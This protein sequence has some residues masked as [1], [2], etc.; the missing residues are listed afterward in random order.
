MENYIVNES[1]KELREKGRNILQGKWWQ[2]I[3]TFIIVM[4]CMSLVPELITVIFGTDMVF[5]IIS[6]LYMLLII[7]P[8]AMGMTKYMLDM[9]RGNE[10]SS[11]TAFSGFERF[12]KTVGLALYMSLLVTLWSLLLII[13]GIIAMYRY[14]MAFYI[15]ADNPELSITECIN[16]SKKMMNGNKAKMFL[17]QLS[18]IGWYL[19]S[20]VVIIALIVLTSSMTILR[21][22]QLAY[23]AAY[24]T[25]VPTSMAIYLIVSVILTTIV[26]TPIA[27]YLQ[28]AI[29]GF[30]RLL[31]DGKEINK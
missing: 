6:N 5:T 9:S 18:Y 17:M 29:T 8:F 20:A 25:E 22:P 3:G 4:L 19:L 13:P 15:L 27:V 31:T 26:S 23:Y 28:A 12:G 2:A 1:C 21:D 16:E 11:A 14:S 24:S 10:V 30:Y 7:G